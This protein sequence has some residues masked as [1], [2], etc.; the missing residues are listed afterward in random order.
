MISGKRRI[1]HLKFLPDWESCNLLHELRNHLNQTVIIKFYD[2]DQE[3]QITVRRVQ[4][5]PA[6]TK[7]RRHPRYRTYTAL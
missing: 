5:F 7:N 4:R 3:L 1:V 6:L 2:L